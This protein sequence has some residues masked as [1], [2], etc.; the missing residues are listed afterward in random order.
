[1][2]DLE[3][4]LGRARR[5]HAAA[6]RR[7]DADGAAVIARAIEVLEQATAGQIPQQRRPE[8]SGES[9]GSPS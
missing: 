7:G 3:D 9:G 4:S 8:D 5:E 2:P 6:L 1:V